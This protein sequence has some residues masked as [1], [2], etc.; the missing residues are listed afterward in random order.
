MI[1]AGEKAKRGPLSGSFAGAA[2]V[3]SDYPG[4]RS[5]GNQQSKCGS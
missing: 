1:V 2:A 5:L 4:T 3:E